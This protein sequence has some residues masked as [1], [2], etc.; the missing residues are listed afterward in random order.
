MVIYTRGPA[1][2]KFHDH[3]E[4]KHLSRFQIKKYE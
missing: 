3:V 1:P 2:N 4:I